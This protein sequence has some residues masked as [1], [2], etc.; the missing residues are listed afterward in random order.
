MRPTAY[1][2]KTLRKSQDRVLY[3]RWFDEKTVHLSLQLRVSRYLKGD[4]LKEPDDEYRHCYD[5][6]TGQAILCGWWIVQRITQVAPE[7]CQ[8][9]DRGHSF[10]DD[11]MPLWLSTSSAYW[12]KS[13]FWVSEFPLVTQ[14]N[15][16]PNYS[17][18]RLPMLLLRLQKS[19][20]NG[21]S[22]FLRFPLHCEYQRMSTGYSPR[23]SCLAGN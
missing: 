3:W 14:L 23:C 15:W 11:Y 17:S 10:M 7:M 16:A 1:A 12:R 4:L 21:T 20:K 19:G 18:V 5:A 8:F 22:T 2:D 9:L 13:K 6:F